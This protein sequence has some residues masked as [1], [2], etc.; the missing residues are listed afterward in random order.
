MKCPRCHREVAIR[1]DGRVAN[2][3]H[4]IGRG[5]RI[6]GDGC[7]TSGTFGEQGA[8]RATLRA[9]ERELEQMPKRRR[10]LFQASRERE[11]ERLRGLLS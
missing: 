6:S 5:L 11:I 7:L 2:H 4:R 9:V 1:A 10:R 3:G 8:I